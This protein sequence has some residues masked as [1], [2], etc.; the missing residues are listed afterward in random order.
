MIGLAAALGAARTVASPEQ[1]S[2][3]PRGIPLAPPRGRRLDENRSVHVGSPNVAGGTDGRGCFGSPNPFGRGGQRRFHRRNFRQ[4]RRRRLPPPR[5]GRVQ[6]GGLALH[7]ARLPGLE[8]LR[9]GDR[10]PA[11]GVFRQ[12]GRLLRRLRRRGPG[13]EGRAEARQGV[14]HP[15]PGDPGPEDDSCPSRGRDSQTGSGGAL[16]QGRAAVPGADRRLVR[17]LRQ[18]PRPADPPGAA[19]RPGS[20]PGRQTGPRDADQG[21]RLRH[22]LAEA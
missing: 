5:G 18:A 9:A 17:G 20:H 3:F 7:R 12:G 4:G 1:A 11:Q 15:L 6:G 8:F 14:R 16:A 2:L 10:A 19:R 21:H 13:G 22:R